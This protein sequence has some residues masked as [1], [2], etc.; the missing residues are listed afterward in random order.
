MHHSQSEMEEENAPV[1]IVCQP[2]EKGVLAC[3]VYMVMGLWL[4]GAGLQDSF[5]VVSVTSV[6]DG[7]SEAPGGPITAETHGSV[8]LTA[9]K[10]TVSRWLPALHLRFP[11]RHQSDS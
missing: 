4:S 2:I 11:P 6:T 10:Q 1:F 8:S 3:T 5:T 9:G 7:V